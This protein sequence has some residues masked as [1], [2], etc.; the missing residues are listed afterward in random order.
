MNKLNVPSQKR[1]LFK[2]L[3]NSPILPLVILAT[4]IITY[5]YFWDI[6]G[7]DRVLSFSAPTSA[8]VWDMGAFYFEL[9][10]I[11]HQFSLH[12]LFFYL[13]KGPIGILISPLSLVSNPFVLVYL[14]TF[15]ISVTALPLYVIANIK[16]K[17]K[18]E[19]LILSISYL[20]FFGIA[21]PNWFDLHFQTFFIPL[22]VTGYL[23][24]LYGKKK[25]AT[26]TLLLSGL[27]RFQYMIFPFIFFT[28]SLYEEKVNNKNK[29][30]S[31][32]FYIG[33][34]ISLLYLASVFIA[35]HVQGVNL[36]LT[37][38]ETSSSLEQRFTSSI[39]DKIF[40][41]LL[42]LSPFLMFPLLS[43]RWILFVLVYPALMFYS[44]FSEYYFPSFIYFQYTAM[45]VPFLFLG[46]IDVLSSI[47]FKNKDRMSSKRGIFKRTQLRSRTAIVL[48]IFVLIIMLGTVY[49]PYG[50]LNS[51]S[52]T[53]F[54]LEKVTNFNISLYE[55][56]STLVD[57]IPTND[58]YILYQ[59]NMPQVIYRDPSA[60]SAYLF[61]YA[62]NYTFFIDGHWTSNVDYIIADPYSNWFTA[63]GGNIGVSGSSPLD[64][65]NV[66]DHYLS[67]NNYGILAEW[68]GIML[69]KRA[70]SGSPL[71]YF[72]DNNFFSARSLYVLS[73]SYRSNGTIESTQLTN[74]E[75]LWYGPYTVLQPGHYRVT[76]QVETSN[77]DVNNV[78]TLRYSY[79][80]PAGVI[81]VI[82][83][84]NVTGEQ[85]ARPNVWT[86]ISFNI[87][88][89]NLYD[90]VE[91]AGQNFHWQGTFT[92]KGIWLKE[93]SYDY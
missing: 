49:E 52:Q 35:Y 59:N 77:I 88:A 5:N 73:S 27:V 91:F 29:K 57:L 3:G 41:L 36:G 93:L 16:L 39:D 68:D 15:A 37:I 71:I 42:F 53:N 56:Y 66:L 22:F 81:S 40:T 32:I 12:V 82:T 47:E 33:P 46:V 60:L 62:A 30:V 20:L 19:S 10:Q 6:M 78:F 18:F 63:S 24:S 8:T 17:S 28:I 13:E 48:V 54:D 92:I 44:G 75:T 51:Y 21:G 14:Q 79:I 89:A 43:K 74:G 85:F 38:H 87:T 45:I 1:S 80:N 72:P 2:G 65:Y 50:P 9:W 84:V 69:L 31:K 55:G 67:S 83:L 61:G 26:A 90:F 4:A 34:L 11:T 58:P 86:N 76:I 23:L 25:L 7:V 70:Y 64:M